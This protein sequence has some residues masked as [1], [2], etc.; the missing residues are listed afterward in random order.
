LLLNPMKSEAIQFT[1]VIVSSLFHLS[2]VSN[3]V[4]QSSPLQQ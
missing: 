2:R 1:G 4:I 3:A